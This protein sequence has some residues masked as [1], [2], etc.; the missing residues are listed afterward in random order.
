ML[1]FIDF[2]L[3]TGQ[4]IHHLILTAVY[5]GRIY[6]IL[7]NLEVR[8]DG[9]ELTNVFWLYLILLIPFLQ[10]FLTFSQKYI[11]DVVGDVDEE[12]FLFIPERLRN[13][14]EQIN[15]G[16]CEV[17]S[18]YLIMLKD[19]EEESNKL[20]EIEPIFLTLI[21]LLNRLNLVPIQ[22]RREVSRSIL[23]DVRQTRL[24]VFVCD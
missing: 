19:I 6:Q 3:I 18:L 12:Q 21:D 15:E 9:P 20:Q 22:N 1:G 4:L 13:F 23:F 5:L 16:H 14:S 7:L 2:D 24:G 10:D 11:A 8:L 17:Q